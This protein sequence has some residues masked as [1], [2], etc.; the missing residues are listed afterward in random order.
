MK[1]PEDA[2]QGSAVGGRACGSLSLVNPGFQSH[3]LQWMSKLQH[4]LTNGFL[5]G[6]K[7][8]LEKASL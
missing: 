8:S 6:V 2:G 7:K 3:H 1:L 5:P 4:V